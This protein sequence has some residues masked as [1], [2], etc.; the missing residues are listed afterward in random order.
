[1]AEDVPTTIIMGATGPYISRYDGLFSD[2]RLEYLAL[3]GIAPAGDEEVRLLD[4]HETEPVPDGVP[5]E[6]A[7]RP[8]GP[9]GAVADHI[10]FYRPTIAGSAVA[11]RKPEVLFDAD[12]VQAQVTDWGLATLRTAAGVR[13][14]LRTWEC[15]ARETV[16]G[17]E[18]VDAVERVV[19]GD[20][21]AFCSLLD[22]ARGGR[23]VFW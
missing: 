10:G 18:A 8:D 6:G 19:S 4:A 9:F 14:P 12:A 11:P 20:R 23:R 3:F 15:R 22:G 13:E 16:G 21:Q 1:M 5:P 7:T 17:V 2:L